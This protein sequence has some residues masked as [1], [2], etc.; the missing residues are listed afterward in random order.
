[1]ASNTF[2]PPGTT[3]ELTVLYDTPKEGVSR[4]GPYR[5]YRVSTADGAEHTFF[6]PRSLFPELD[7]LQIRRGSQLRVRATE[8]I[9]SDGRIV[10][11]LE[12]V[13]SAPASPTPA[14]EPGAQALPPRRSS[15]SDS[16]LACV[17]LKAA[18]QAR[19]PVDRPEDALSV[20]E[21][22]LVWLQG[23]AT[24][25]TGSATP[26]GGCRSAGA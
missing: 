11:K 6:P 25:P 10:P 20:A 13:G 19:G 5:A 21:T 3:T 7:R 24:G 4:F 14:P 17:A 9:S 16:I 8:R 26:D 12:L 15:S 23:H 2:L 1:M 22:Y 18:V